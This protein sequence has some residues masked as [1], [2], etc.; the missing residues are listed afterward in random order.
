[1]S[2][3]VYIGGA[4]SSFL[5]EKG[6]VNWVKKY[7]KVVYCKDWG[8]KL[9]L[10]IYYWNAADAKAKTLKLKEVINISYNEKTKKFK[11]HNKIN[12]NHYVNIPRVSQSLQAALPQKVQLNRFRKIFN[13]KF[14]HTGVKIPAP[15]SMEDNWAGALLLAVYK[16]NS[17]AFKEYLDYGGCGY[18]GRLYPILNKYK[19]FDNFIYYKFGKGKV[20]RKMVFNLIKDHIHLTG[21][22]FFAKLFKKYL[23]VDEMQVIYKNCLSD[24]MYRIGISTDARDARLNIWP[25]LVR[26]YGIKKLKNMMMPVFRG[27]ES[28]RRTFL[29]E[30]WDML[31]MLHG[32]E[33]RAGKS[34]NFIDVASFKELHDYAAKEWSKIKNPCVVFEYKKGAVE[35]DNATVGDFKIVLPKNSYELIDWGQKM[36]NC[37]GSYSSLIKNNNCLVLGVEKGGELKYNIEIR[38]GAIGQF[39][40]PRNSSPPLEDKSVVEEFLVEKK[41]IN[42]KSVPADNFDVLM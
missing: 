29:Y 31:R 23:T 26:F 34:F 17:P 9:T 6:W 16:H 13:K 5:V 19:D 1:M 42:M 33:E 8:D 4:P 22:L 2:K 27:E 14:Q 7:P 15:K 24:G 18:H 35:I 28:E 3:A 32:Y 20:I 40:G 11:L 21:F 36:S 41:L 39:Y 25:Q 38:G 10:L 12:E 37:V 30:F